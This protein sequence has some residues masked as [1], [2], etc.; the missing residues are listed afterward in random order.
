MNKLHQVNT[1]IASRS[2]KIAMLAMSIAVGAAGSAAAANAPITAC[3]K[4][5]STSGYYQVTKSLTAASGTNCITITG[6]N[7][8]VD[9]LN[10]NGGDPCNA[11]SIKSDSSSSSSI[12]IYV[13]STAKNTFIQGENSIVAGFGY[14]IYDQGTGTTVDD[15]NVSNNNTAG[16]GLGGTGGSVS[17]FY[18]GVLQHF[19][20]GGACFPSLANPPEFGVSMLSATNSQIF[21]GILSANNYG[22]IETSSTGSTVA[23]MLSGSNNADGYQFNTGSKNYIYDDLAGVDGF[24][25]PPLFG[26]G[27]FGINVISDTG[28]LVTDNT[29][30]GNTDDDIN[31][32]SDPTCSSNTYWFNFATNV[33]TPCI[34]NK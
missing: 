8:T 11:T 28:D 13:K 9:I 24:T 17:N 4:T 19:P 34:L 15:I 14:G 21:N 2:I 10:S 1:A 16:V 20:A 3:G 26:N 18:A 31:A 25:T 5:L 23:L 30:G 12:G 27:G 32:A 33:S 6:S 29:A 22:F 7:I